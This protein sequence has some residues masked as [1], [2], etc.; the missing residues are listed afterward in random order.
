MKKYIIFLLMLCFAISYAQQDDIK[1]LIKK[2]KQRNTEAQYELGS[3]YFTGNNVEKSY[4]KAV[5]WFTK[6]AEQEHAEAQYALGIFLLNGAGIKQSK[7]KAVYWLRKACE[8]SNNN[9]CD[10]LNELK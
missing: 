10:I 7:S 2:A 1:T 6:A 8:N 3:S 5:Y 9:A 4:E